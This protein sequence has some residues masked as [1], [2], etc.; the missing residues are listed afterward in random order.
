MGIH[1]VDGKRFRRAVVAGAD[2]VRHMREYLNRINV[3]PVA[4]GDTGTNM[5][6]S[7]SATAD[8]AKK[9]E[10]GDLAQASQDVAEASILGAKGNSGLIMAHWFLG[11][12]KALGK[13]ARVGAKDLAHA[14]GRATIQVYE[15]IDK[16]TEGTILTVMREGSDAAARAA[17][18]G[19]DVGGIMEE[20]LDASRAA[21]RRTPEMLAV[22][23][24]SKVVD[25][26]GQGFVHFLEG[27]KRTFEGAPP[28]VAR[29]EDLH[30]DTTHPSINVEKLEGRYCT[31]VVVRGRNFD[32]ELLKARFAPLGS[33]L[34][35]ASTGVV[36]KL[37]IHTDHPDK[38]FH[39]AT[40]WGT[41]EER[42]VDDMLRQSEERQSHTQEA[43]VPLAQQPSTVAI[44]CD[45]TCDLSLETRRE[46]GIETAPLSILFGDDVY[47]DQV[48]MSTTQF[49]ERLQSDPH[50]PSTSQPPP[51]EFVQALERIRP[52]RQA[53]I[54][55][56]SRTFSGTYRSALSAAKLVDHPRVEVFD[57]ATAC[58]GLGM[59]VVCAAR[60]AQRGASVEEI[61]H[62]LEVWRDR[63]GLF[64]TVATLDYLKKGGR[65][66]TAAHLVGS[67]LRMRPIL[68][69]RE[70]QVR[71]VAKA[72]G[73]DDAYEKLLESFAAVVPKEQRVRL[74]LLDS[75]SSDRLDPAEARVRERNVVVES[76]RGQISG[77]VGTHVGPGAWGLFY[78]LVGEDDPLL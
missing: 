61:L 77:V 45:S 63:G 27:V 20:F 8:A 65:I 68:S 78:Q 46:Y 49:Y 48:D 70:G 28:P 19:R 14:F 55:T 15:A 17:E 16:P 47:R 71:A 67:F 58:M 50:H 24:E 62:W 4:D 52:D 73:D 54:I 75:T 31:E 1:Y 64:F 74:A 36:F 44:L 39:L 40:R 11:F 10:D 30:A 57:S 34:L 2:W 56:L 60:L 66:G 59:L 26:G 76:F 13:K 53:I 6:L 3:F 37:H 12:S 51:R 72:R 38:V 9:S 5:A 43:L 21:L 22:L 41:I 69:L 42:K 33:S 23:R 7:L 25:A 35:V 18:R 29:P 32:P